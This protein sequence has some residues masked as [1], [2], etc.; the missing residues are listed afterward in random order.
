MPRFAFAAPTGP[1]TMR[2]PDEATARALLE[3]HLHH[4]NPT[5]DGDQPYTTDQ[6]NQIR[7]QQ[8]ERAATLPITAAGT[9]RPCPTCNGTGNTWGLTCRTCDGD[10]NIPTTQ[11]ITRRTS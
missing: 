10:G 4:P 7:Q 8:A 2:A 9:S 11:A 5:G 6:L 3:S 1:R